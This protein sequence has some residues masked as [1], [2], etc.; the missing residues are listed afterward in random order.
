MSKKLLEGLWESEKAK[1]IGSLPKTKKSLTSLLNHPEIE[2]K[3]GEESYVEIS[4]LEILKQIV[5]NTLNDQLMLPF[6]FQKKKSQYYLLGNKLEQ[7]V[8]ETL[9]GLTPSSPFLLEVYMPRSSYY[10]Y[11]FKRIQ[12]KIPTLVF[13]TFYVDSQSS[14]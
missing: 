5:P 8:V 14:L 11:H 13:L 3:N 9:L 4:E 10:V 1:I 2:L 12:S 7:W 6:I